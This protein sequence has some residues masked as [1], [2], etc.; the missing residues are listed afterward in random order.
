MTA[1]MSILNGYVFLMVNYRFEPHLLRLL[2]KSL[3]RFCFVCLFLVFKTNFKTFLCYPVSYCL[4]FEFGI[5]S[6]IKNVIKKIV[7][8]E[9]MVTFELKGSGS[10]ANMLH[11]HS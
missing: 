6:I 9:T 1:L 3:I 8:T 11:F 5:N 4:N 10:E 2:L 7:I